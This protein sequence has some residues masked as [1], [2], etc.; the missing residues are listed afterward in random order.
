MRQQFNRIDWS[1]PDQIGNIHIGHTHWPIAANE[2]VL[3]ILGEQIIEIVNWVSR[4]R[5][6]QSYI[7]FYLSWVRASP[8]EAN[9]LRFAFAE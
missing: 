4:A 2:I 1:E 6:N 9:F 5:F 8:I 3:R 7:S